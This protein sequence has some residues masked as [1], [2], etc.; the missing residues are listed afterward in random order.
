[1]VKN[2]GADDAIAKFSLITKLFNGGY[3]SSR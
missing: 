3:E 1:M 2:I